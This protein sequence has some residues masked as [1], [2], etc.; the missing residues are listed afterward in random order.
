MGGTA[1]LTSMYEDLKAV[2]RRTLT[3][4][5]HIDDSLER[6]ERVDAE[7]RTVNDWQ[8][9]LSSVLTQD[10]RNNNKRMR[11]AYG[12]AQSSDQHIEA[13]LQSDPT[14]ESLRIVSLS[15]EGLLKLFPTAVPNLLDYDEDLDGEDGDISR[16]EEA[17]HEMADLFV[18]RDEAVSKV[19][20]LA[21]K[22][23]LEMSTAARRCWRAS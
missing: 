22:D 9:T 17:L 3:S 11:E 21:T 5:A 18:S 8:G 2:A 10:V 19:R 16:L 7:F 15:R 14:Q 23:I 12:A 20:T 6:E 1:R 4:M 13:D